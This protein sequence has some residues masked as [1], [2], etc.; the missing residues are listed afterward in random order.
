MAI[1]DLYWQYGTLPLKGSFYPNET[2]KTYDP[3]RVYEN[4]GYIYPQ[5]NT[6]NTNEAFN[7]LLDPKVKVYSKEKGSIYLL[8]YWR[9]VSRELEFIQSGCKDWSAKKIMICDVDYMIDL[10]RQEVDSFWSM[11][12]LQ[13]QDR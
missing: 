13:R 7:N 6:F 2:Y 8:V 9:E 10:L 1:N 4:S 12:E 3:Y 11:V 5:V